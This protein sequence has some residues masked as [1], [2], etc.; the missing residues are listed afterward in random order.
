MV[1]YLSKLC[2][3]LSTSM[4]GDDRQTT[5]KVIG[6]EGVAIP[7]VPESIGL[8]ATELVMNA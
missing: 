2:A 4:I 7:R 8:I 5:I 3:T 1:P 6:Q